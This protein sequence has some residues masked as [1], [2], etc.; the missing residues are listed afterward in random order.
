MY[1]L[2]YLHWGDDEPSAPARVMMPMAG[3]G[4]G[5]HFLPEVGD[6]VVVA[7]EMGDTNFPI[8]MGA[9]WNRENTAPNQARTSPENHIRTIVT[10][11]GHELTF[12]DTPGAQKVKLKT[13]GGHELVLD[14]LPGLGEVKLSSRSG[15]SLTFTEL[16]IPSATLQ[17][18]G[19]TITMGATGVTIQSLTI[20]LLT[21]PGG[22]SM[23]GK[24]TI[25]HS[26][27]P[28][29]VLPAM[30]GPVSPA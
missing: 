19:A 29:P 7:F 3:N 26:H 20:S 25:L 28:P 30:T 16:P 24:P 17:V 12:D 13:Q 22:V 5:M 15:C 11:S 27:V 23:E 8:I 9:V 14:D 4:T 6:E 1:R 2:Q 21:L 10:R 18:P